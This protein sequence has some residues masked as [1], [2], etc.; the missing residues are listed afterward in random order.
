MN[1]LTVSDIDVSDK[2]VLVRVDF[3]VPLKDGKVTDDTRIRASLPTIQYLL[4][5][6]AAVILMSHLG[7]PKG[8][9][10]EELKMFSVAKRLSEILGVEVKQAED[11]VGDEVARA[12]S[13]LKPGEILLLE[14]LRFHPEETENDPEFS[15]ELASLADIYVNDAF[16]TAHRAHA[17]TVG[18]AEHLTAAAGFLMKREMEVLS[19]ILFYPSRPF[20]A[21]VGGAKISDKIGVIEYLSTKADTILIGGGMANTFLK[22]GGFDLA[23]SLVEEE[24]IEQAASILKQYNSYVEVGSSI[25]T[26]FGL[27]KGD[28]KSGSFEKYN[29][30]LLLPRDVVIAQDIKDGEETKIVSPNNIPLGWKALDIGKETIKEYVD[31]IKNASTIVW[32]GP[33][34]V[35]EYDQFANGTM[36]I[37]KAVAES[38]GKAFV[39]GGD[40]VA[41]VEKLGLVNDIYHIST[42]GGASLEFLE[43]KNLPGIEVLKNKD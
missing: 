14:N 31:Y 2:R 13:E 37:A 15:K 21:I 12:A 35:F 3:N 1:K 16:G 39:G 29:C 32:N 8:T 34:G 18:V 26:R 9:F 6:K 25:S 23:D 36:E 33:M 19:E 4:E 22:A 30:E 28:E 40:S 41:A 42:G 20:V 11:C 27:K 5:K 24:K 43:G 10:E 17:S 38:N 7:R